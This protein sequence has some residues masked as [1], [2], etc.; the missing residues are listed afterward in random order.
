MD[1]IWSKDVVFS[2]VKQQYLTQHERRC[3][4]G[5]N[6]KCKMQY[7]NNIK[8][9]NSYKPKDSILCELVLVLF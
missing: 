4:D 1:G 9:I 2:L 8:A 6:K 7:F 5:F 3:I